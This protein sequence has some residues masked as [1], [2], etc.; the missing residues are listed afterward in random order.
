M[1]PMDA[2]WSVLKADPATRL[3]H[4]PM[5][6]RP[7]LHM[8]SSTMH[9]AIVGM[10]QGIGEGRSPVPKSNFEFSRPLSAYQPAP[11]MS[12]SPVDPIPDRPL[13]PGSEALAAPQQTSPAPPP[14][15]PEFMA[16]I[17]ADEKE[18]QRRKTER[19]E[20]KD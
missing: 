9:P 19:E 7:G 6:L 13:P 10:M 12:A 8:R 16:R 20:R 11:T 18:S 4:E 2:A 14:A 3:R 15:D 1:N 5:P 17:R